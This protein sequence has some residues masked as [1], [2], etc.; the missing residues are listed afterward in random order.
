MVSVHIYTDTHHKSCANVITLPFVL[1][2]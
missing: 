2:K 1:V